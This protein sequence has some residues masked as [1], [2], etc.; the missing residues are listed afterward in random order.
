MAM[1][2]N[3]KTPPNLNKA[4]TMAAVAIAITVFLI[5]LFV[6]MSL[7]APVTPVTVNELYDDRIDRNDDGAIDEDDLPIEWQS[8]ELGDRVLVRDR[9]DDVFWD[10]DTNQTYITLVG[11][12]G[13]Y[14]GGG[15]PQAR[16]SG[17][18]ADDYSVGDIVTFE[19]EMI[20]DR[21][22]TVIMPSHWTIVE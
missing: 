19:T 14:E 12:T 20:I 6:Y 5:I 15:R 16:V 10:Y 9:I 4:K 17:N 8:Y 18:V 22:E 1:E 7:N 11:Y 13:N 3:G 2:N 21:T